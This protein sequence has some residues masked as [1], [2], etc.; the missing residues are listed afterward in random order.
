MVSSCA[1]CNRMKPWASAFMGMGAGLIYLGL[2]RFMVRIKVDDPL[3][4]FAVHAGGGL[5]GLLSACIIAHDGIIYAIY[6]AI[7]NKHGSL[8]CRRAFAQLVWQI[9]CA[10]AIIIWSL[11]WMLPVLLFLKKIGK[12]RV[13]AEVEINGLDIH[14]HGE[15]AYPSNAY[16][17]GWDGYKHKNIES[18]RHTQCHWKFSALDECKSIY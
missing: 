13:A 17:H 11:L 14:K 10:V 9:I 4:A 7:G 15:A 2:S 18:T 5:W 8:S 16:G 12:L 6:D 1:G 3:D